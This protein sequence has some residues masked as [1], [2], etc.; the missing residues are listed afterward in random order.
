M[1]GEVRTNHILRTKPVFT[2]QPCMFWPNLFWRGYDFWGTRSNFLW[3]AFR[4]TGFTRKV[5]DKVIYHALAFFIFVMQSC[6]HYIIDTYFAPHNII[7][8]IAKSAKEVKQNV[9]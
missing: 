8:R 7:P 9:P 2:A 6:F 1:V 3:S 5:F 4:V